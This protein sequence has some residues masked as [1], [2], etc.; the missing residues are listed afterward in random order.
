MS[1]AG[2]CTAKA[3]NDVPTPPGYHRHVVLVRHGNYSAFN[4]YHFQPSAYSHI[5]CMVTGLHWR[6]KAGY[7]ALLPDA[8]DQEAQRAVPA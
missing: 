6:T 5:R 4:G 2:A 1:F 3:S 8:T 7:V